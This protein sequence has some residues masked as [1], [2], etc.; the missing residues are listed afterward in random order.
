MDLDIF[1]SP[2]FYQD[3]TFFNPAFLHSLWLPDF[4]KGKSLPGA[5][6]H[7][8]NTK[9]RTLGLKFKTC[10]ITGLFSPLLHAA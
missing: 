1:T 6:F 3:G 10:I 7:M 2:G 9:W 5:P 4:P 8:T